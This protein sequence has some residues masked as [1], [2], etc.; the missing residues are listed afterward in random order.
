MRATSR[1]GGQAMNPGL[2]KKPVRSPWSPSADRTPPS[3]GIAG[4]FASVAVMM[5]LAFLSYRWLDGGKRMLFPVLAAFFLAIVTPVTIIAIRHQVRL[6][7]IKLIDLFAKNFRF[8]TGHA[9]SDAARAEGAAEG[10]ALQPV[11]ADEAV[12]AAHAA[13]PN[14]AVAAAPTARQA[15]GDD[16]KHNVS[17]EFV[18]DKYFA[19]L[20][21]VE[22]REP[23]LSDVPR[24]PMM[25]HADWMLL[26]CALPY[27]VVCWLG[28]L[29]LFAPLPEAANT[30]S[31]GLVESW[32][33]PSIL[34]VGGLSREYVLRGHGLLEA[35]HVNVLTIALLAFAGAYFFTIQLMLRAVAVFDLSAVTF[36][37]AFAH[38]VLAMLLAVV[39]YRV[40]P[41]VEQ[42]TGGVETLKQVL[43]VPPSEPAV[44]ATAPAP[45]ASRAMPVAPAS[46]PSA[47]LLLPDPCA[48][49][50]ACR[51][52]NP[53][54]GVG[55]LWLFIAFALG[56]VPDAA[57]QHLL[58][59]SGLTFKARYGEVEKHT[60]I[61]PL[62]ILDGVDPFIAFRLEEAN[63]FDIQNLA[64]ANPIMLHVES[65]F[66]IY[67]TID[68]V[69]Q[70][71]LCTV[72]GPDRFL[73]LK[74]LHIRTIFDLERAV[75]AERPRA[76]AAS[77]E[78]RSPNP[79][80]VAAIGRILL[81]DTERDVKLR[82]A[83]ELGPHPGA[84]LGGATEDAL[85]AATQA[86]V[87][88]MID[89]LHVHRLRQVWKH[90]DAELGEGSLRF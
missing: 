24:F 11:A 60:K 42:F 48:A 75:I 6:N 64:T 18:K 15:G 55:P 81:Q 5:V 16:K 71:Q 31:S 80:L 69:A 77:P 79:T 17:F 65:P 52:G 85:V 8:E 12:P 83:F 62:T 32:F 44:R 3:R 70:A 9:G 37:R 51:A 63:I 73:L 82:E 76:G 25:L 56:F 47:G 89:D 74:T 14:D 41:S 26:V 34:F 54:T 53:L 7:R 50:G 57:I 61:I 20:D 59:K 36:L 40:V 19:D 88:V 90:I 84:P 33:Q 68:W 35:W 66:G 72:V 43:G 39:I 27:M 23:K 58:K 87:T 46:G 10:G 45:S 21:L 1:S 13:V 22:D 28:A 4:L 29:L 49:E 67:E 78:V 86:M 30:N 38:I 2:T